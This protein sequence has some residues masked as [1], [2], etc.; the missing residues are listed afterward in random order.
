MADKSMKFTLD[1]NAKTKGLTDAA[2]LVEDLSDELGDGESA[3][4]D[5][6]EA[7]RRAADDMETDMRETAAMAD[8]LGAALGPEL[9]AKIGQ[10]N[11]ETMATKLR[12]V[13]VDA[14][15][16]DADIDELADG[17]RRLDQAA[18]AAGSGGLNN[19][20]D[21]MKRVGVEA[22]NSNNV[23]ANFAGNAAQELPGVAGAFGPLNMAISQFVEYG[24]E[25]NI[26]IKNL[27][28]MAGPMMGVAVA[29]ELVARYQK[30]VADIKA[31]NKSQI[32][33]FVGSLKEGANVADD[34]RQSLLD[35]G[36]VEFKMNR[37]FGGDI[38]DDLA[39]AGVT[40][41]QFFAA[42]EGGQEGIQGLVDAMK[43]AGVNGGDLANIT[44]AAASQQE[45]LNQAHKTYAELQK[46]GIAPTDEQAAATKKAA[47]AADEAATKA[48]KLA[49]ALNKQRDAALEA[50]SSLWDVEE[51]TIN[52]KQDYDEYLLSLADGE[53][54]LEDLRLAQIDQVQ[55]LAD[56]AEKMVEQQGVDADSEQGV[57]DQIGALTEMKDQF[58]LLAAE[59]D[60]YIA[61][62]KRIPG[63]VNTSVGYTVYGTTARV[64]GIGVNAR[65][66]DNWRGGETWVGEE[67]PEIVNLP[68]GSR[69]TPAERSAAMAA[70]RA[71]P[72]LDAV[73]FALVVGPMIARAIRQELRSA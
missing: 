14:G 67:G 70:E 31:F 19:A 60:R 8:R 29:M 61:A 20:A 62:L 42:V 72:G 25:G 59:I 28:K 63:T 53:T 9:A 49:E 48:E 71:A 26:N 52:A 17:I 65:G 56:L 40:F 32:D 33:G 7:M 15:A 68:P 50:A 73:A 64:G 30:Q 35:A 69:V 45:N 58:P 4:K 5:L 16:T 39:R 34:F 66:T 3:A 37:T 44:M 11:L 36:K 27:A 22:D 47:D 1:F 51:A 13:G 10:G 6:A 24:A 38:L 55:G 21:G 46:A 57:R 23:M 43:A 54:A 12:S 2:R 41:D 18:D